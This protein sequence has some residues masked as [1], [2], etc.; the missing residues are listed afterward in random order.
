MNAI[1]SPG[2]GHNGGPPMTNTS[3]P[4]KLLPFFTEHAHF[5]I[6]YG[7]RASAK[8]WTIARLLILLAYAEAGHL[9]LCTRE[10][11][12]SIADSVHALLK[13]QIFALGLAPWFDIT[14]R[15][16]RC[17]TNGS[18]FIFKGLHH[19][20][21][22]IKSTE[23]VTICWIEE[24]QV[25]SQVSWA[26]LEPTIRTTNRNSKVLPGGR[27]PEIWASFNPLDDEDHLYKLFVAPLDMSDPKKA[28]QNAAYLQM[29][30]EESIIVEMN[31]R[32]NP[33]FSNSS[34]RSRK[35][36]RAADPDAYDWVWEGKTKR[37]SEAAVFRGRYFVREFKVPAGLHPYFGADFGF[38][39]DPSTLIRF[40]IEELEDDRRRLYIDYEAYGVGIETD[41]LPAFYAGGAS[42]YNSHEY[43]EGVPGCT[44]W[45][46]KADNARP[47]TISFLTNKSFHISGAEKWKG[48][49]ED[50]VSFL[51]GYSEILIHPRCHNTAQEFRLYSYK[52]DKRQ[53]PPTILPVIVDKHNHCIDA[54]RYGHDGIITQ[55]GMDVW[56]KLSA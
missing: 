28:V 45:P 16:I 6:T 36:M 30:T 17:R 56:G 34:D 25:V 41:D 9:I 23:G 14:D 43:Y 24:A 33:W 53:D 19:N 4:D 26:V 55:G 12:T 40:F 8:S 2:A 7:G 35:F 31:W 10:F 54:L 21:N 38:A 51:K 46:I 15:E 22:E 44:Q 42:I 48:C 27:P 52:V 1:S 13:G 47:E 32:D 50:G 49:V 37:I 5:K 11:Q 18:R 20:I 29:R 3:F 39:N